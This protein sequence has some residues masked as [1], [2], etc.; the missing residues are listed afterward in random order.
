MLNSISVL[1]FL[2]IATSLSAQELTHY[3]C[4]DET[5][6]LMSLT[7]SWDNILKAGN[8]LPKNCFDGYFAEGISENLV[9]KIGNDWEGFIKLIETHPKHNKFTQLVLSS[10]NSTVLPKDLLLIKQKASNCC[11]MFKNLCSAIVKQSRLALNEQ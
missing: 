2:F 7:T 11:S 9:V 6:P 5:R 3:P 1:F 10:I 8:N 4:E